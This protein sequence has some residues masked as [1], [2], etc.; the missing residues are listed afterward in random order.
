MGQQ[1]ITGTRM[2][3][4]QAARQERPSLWEVQKQERRKAVLVAAKSLIAASG[5]DKP[6]IEDIAAAA[7]LSTPTVYNYFGTKL[8]LL[9][10]LY[11][12]DR[13]IALSEIATTVAKSWKDPIDFF[14][15]M[16]EADLREDADVPSHALWR[17]IAAAEV[18][19][20]EGRHHATFK[21]INDRHIAAITTAVRRMVE[22]GL[23]VPGTDV[24]AVAE[25][26]HHLSEGFYRKVIAT[27][28]TPF[29]AFRGD[30]KR[31]LKVMLAGIRA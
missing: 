23:L 13:E 3:R 16:L 30:A 8:D 19:Q 17:Q 24:K 15:A 31:Q 14:L 7:G 27:T 5:Y 28:D 6:T 12:E 26:F 10:A 21:G 4:K 1:R 22:E 2:A 25:L 9:L 29:A 18:T 11:L 20:N